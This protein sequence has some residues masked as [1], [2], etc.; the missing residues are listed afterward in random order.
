MRNTRLLNAL[1]M[2]EVDST[3][4]WV[5]RQAGRYLPEYRKIRSEVKDF[6]TLC[7]TP[8]L[9]CEVT[10]QPLKR[11]DLDAAILFS[12]ILTIPEAMGLDLAFVSGE[13]PVFASTVRS[14][15]DVEQLGCPDPN[16]EL[17]YVMDAIQHVKHEL[18]NSVPLIGFSGSPWTLATYMVE[19]RGSKQFAEIRKMLYSSPEILHNLLE[20]LAQSVTHYLKAQIDV[21]VDVVML[22]DSW[23]GVLTPQT[24][25]AFSLQYMTQI[26]S[27]IKAYSDVPIILFTKGGGLW[28][29]EIVGAGSQGVGI[30]WTIPMKQAKKII[31]DRAC[32]QGNLDPAVLYGS[33]TQIEM[34]VQRILQEFGSGNGHIFNLGHGIYP[35]VDPDNVSAMISAIRKFSCKK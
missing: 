24:Y 29:N 13:G 19:G 2:Q 15:R 23:G 21:G 3:P 33:V 12:D 18:N 11:F 34:E 8:D 10:V 16:D 7:K 25:Q 28:L 30:D 5:M 31:G 9:A 27:S 17:G 4:V 14:Q 1:N 22:F 32:I 35:D 20:K 26:I 6:M